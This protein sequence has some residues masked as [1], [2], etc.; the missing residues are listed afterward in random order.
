MVDSGLGLRDH[1]EPGRRFG[2]AATSSARCSP[3]PET[4]VRQVAAL[5]FD[6]HDVRHVVLTIVDADHTGGLADF[7]WAQVHLDGCGSGR[8]AE[9]ARPA[10]K[11]GATCP[12]NAIIGPSAGSG[13]IRA[14]RAVGEASPPAEETCRHR[15]GPGLLGLPGHTRGH[16]AVA[17]DAGDDGC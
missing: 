8:G 5:G 17:G 1:A 16:A 4:A 12:R 3:K 2:S 10:G 14:E 6:P 13:T 9:P 15:T 7:P 11:K